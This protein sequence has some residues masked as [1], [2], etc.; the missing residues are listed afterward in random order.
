MLMLTSCETKT[1]S[2]TV[3]LV[4]TPLS[5]DSSTYSHPYTLTLEDS[6]FEKTPQQFSPQLA[7]AAVLLSSSA[8][9]YDS[10]LDNFDSLG[11]EHKA[12][13]NYGE[14]YDPSA[15]GIVIASKK[16]L[17]Y[18]IVAVAM[19]GTYA[20]EWYSNFDIGRDLSDTGVHEGFDIARNFALDKIEMYMVNYGVD[21][22]HCKFLVTGHSRGA[23]V[24]NLTAKSLID[25]YGADNIYAYTFATPNTTTLEEAVSERYSGIFNFV[26]PDD[27]IAYIPLDSW[28]FTKYGT[29]I[30]FPS[31]NSDELYSEK[32]Q[33]VKEKYL[34]YRGREF[35]TYPDHSVIQQFFAAANDLAPTVKDYYDTQYEIAGLSMS[36][37]DYMNMVAQLLNEEN[38][39]SNGLIM[40]GSEDT[41][42]EEITHFITYGMEQNTTAMLDYE[43]SLI[44]YAHPAETYLCWLE[45]YIEYM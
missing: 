38:L 2:F 28:G 41:P 33:K 29:T 35:K 25:I 22:D 16:V 19:R 34:L 17:D 9:K 45:V 4:T 7:K 37:Y 13:F 21:R 27:F 5:T 24:A 44:S 20:H 10:A 31:K 23:A 18:T 26:N 30:V 3:N 15:V 36:L 43:N 39:I 32:L 6:V 42:F 11:F 12:K 8:Y 40:L 1:Q 14:N